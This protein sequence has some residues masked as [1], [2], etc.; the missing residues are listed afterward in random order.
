[1]SSAIITRNDGIAL[2]LFIFNLPP[3][4]GSALASSL[5][6]IPTHMLTVATKIM[7]YMI[8]KGPPELMPVT[9]AAEIPNQEF[10]REKPTPSTDHIEKFLFMSCEYPIAASRIASMSI[11]S[12]WLH[13]EDEDVCGS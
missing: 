7:P 5:K 13:D 9:R 1:M 4:F 10:V 3:A 11:V 12:I 6:L 2:G 8:N